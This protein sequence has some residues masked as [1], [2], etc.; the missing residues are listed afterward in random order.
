MSL[1]N[2][3][4]RFD[5]KEKSL[6]LQGLRRILW[7]EENRLSMLQDKKEIEQIENLIERLTEPFEESTGE[8]AIDRMP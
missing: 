4:M 1:D 2:M 8:Q 5:S 7:E 3:L 6:I